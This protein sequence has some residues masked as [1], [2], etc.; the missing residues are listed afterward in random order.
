MQTFEVEIKLMVHA[1][2]AG[3]AE[4]PPNAPSVNGLRGSPAPRV[5]ETCWHTSV[6]AGVL[7]H[8]CDHKLPND[9]TIQYNHDRLVAQSETK[10]LR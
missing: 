1:Q 10:S 2:R 8:S 7:A 4:S 5:R 3:V 9:N 6:V